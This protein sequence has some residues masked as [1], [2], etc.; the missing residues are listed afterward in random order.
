MDRLCG[1]LGWGSVHG[2]GV[3]EHGS[4]L[5]QTVHC[6]LPTRASPGPMESCFVRYSCKVWDASADNLQTSMLPVN[7]SR[8]GTRAWEE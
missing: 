2:A 8:H 7:N 4:H 1:K 5:T 3:L 6:A